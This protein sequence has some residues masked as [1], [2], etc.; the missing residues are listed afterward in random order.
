MRYWAS[1]YSVTLKT[2]LG[3]VQG[4]WKWRRSINH[5]RLTI[6]VRHCKYSSIWYSFFSYLTLNDINDLEIW[7]R[8]HSR[9]FKLAPFKSLG[10]VS[11][12]PSIVTWRY[13]V[14]SARYSDLLVENRNF[15]TPPVFSAPSGGDSVGILW[16]CLMPIK[17]QWLGYRMVKKTMTI[18]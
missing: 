16:R 3:V 5:I 11:Y 8:G 12:S 9:S 13:L 10:V 15:F 18:C 2:G 1:K 17:L 7:V 4:H 14:S 6:L